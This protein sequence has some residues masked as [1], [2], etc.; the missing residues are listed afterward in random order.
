MN[1]NKAIFS[2][3]L[4]NKRRNWY[5]FPCGDRVCVLSIVGIEGRGQFW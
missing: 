5:T 2:S 4:I 3:I 1:Y